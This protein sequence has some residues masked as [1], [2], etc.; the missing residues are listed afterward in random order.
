MPSDEV[1]RLSEF[2]E[3]G[4]SLRAEW[5]SIIDDATKRIGGV[6]EDRCRVTVTGKL[7]G[8]GHDFQV[9]GELR[10]S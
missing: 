3:D 1:Q 5:E 4:R 9:L 8:R 10:D 6:G 7:G 2:D